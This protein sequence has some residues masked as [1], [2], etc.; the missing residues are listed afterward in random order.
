MSMDSYPFIGYAD[1]ASRSQAA[2]PT[3]VIVSPTNELVSSRGISLGA[4]TTNIVEYNV[5]IGLLL[6]AINFGIRHLVI[7]LDS[8]LVVRKLN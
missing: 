2:S 3:W 6:E 1:K 8:Q 7:R 4:M 5:I